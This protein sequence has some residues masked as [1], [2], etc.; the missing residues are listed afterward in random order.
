MDN[1]D[2]VVILINEC[3]RMGISVLP[4]N[5]NE[6]H[7]EFRAT[8]R[9]DIQF[10]LGAVKNVGRSAIQSIIEARH[11]HGEFEDIFD[12]ASRVDLRLVNKRVLESLVF[13]GALDD[14]HGHRAQLAAAAPAAIELGQRLSRERES[15]QTSLFGGGGD[16]DNVAVVQPRKLPEAEPWP[17]SLALANEKDVLGF[18]V[19]GHPLARYG[20][21]LK[22]F[23]TAS[24]AGL[25][26]MENKEQVRIG[27]IITEIKTT[28]DRKG[29]RMAFVMLEDFT[30]SVEAVV[31]SDCYAEHHEAIRREAAVIMDGRIAM[32][33]ED[34]AKIIVN[35][36]VPLARAMQRYVER[37][38]IELATAGL[39][40]EL[41]ESLKAALLRHPGRCP[42]ELVLHSKEGEDRKI[43]VGSIRIEPS[44]A[45]M[46]ELEPLVGEAAVH[47]VGAV[48]HGGVPEPAF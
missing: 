8:P 7:I 34:D 48:Q 46:D 14:L 22:A 42:V 11:E 19:T 28:D 31:F 4:P 23:A 16:D 39:E 15:G 20:R 44:P 6:G 38:S 5:V 1:T 32:K 25:R 30:G 45:L 3:K 10:G 41:L 40:D 33:G 17:D 27:G 36:V 9:N 24:V 12:L 37:V 29:K 43:R 47:L 21:E 26:E 35:D 13:A 2:R 18:Y